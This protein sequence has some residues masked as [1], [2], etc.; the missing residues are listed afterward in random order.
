MGEQ[1]KSM[2]S[3]QYV[4]SFAALALLFISLSG[5]ASFLVNGQKRWEII[6]PAS[7]RKADYV[8]L[9][10]AGRSLMAGHSIY[11]NNRGCGEEFNDP[12]A[13]EN[14]VRYV[15]PPLAAYIFAPLAFFSEKTSYLIWSA[16][17]IAII[18]GI[19]ALT[20][21]KLGFTHLET[22][23]LGT[24][25]FLSY[26][27]WFSLERGNFDALVMLFYLSAFFLWLDKRSEY[28]VAFLLAV[29]IL[30]KLF[31]LALLLFFLLKKEWNIIAY[32]IIAAILLSLL[33]GLRFIPEYGAVF[34]KLLVGLSK[35]LFV[36]NHSTICFILRT[37][38]I[39]GLFSDAAVRISIYLSHLINLSLF[40]FIAYHSWRWG[41]RSKLNLMIE[42]CAYLL[43]MSV[44]SAVSYDYK[45]VFMCFMVPVLIKGIVMMNKIKRR[46]FLTLVIYVCM[47]Y[48]L[49]ATWCLIGNHSGL[50]AAILASKFP[51][52]VVLIVS[53]VRMDSILLYD[54]A[55]SP[56]ENNEE[57]RS[58][59]QC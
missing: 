25:V 59:V 39:C 21:K 9:L 20:S 36:A 2:T 43:F 13:G 37:Q 46:S 14:E 23:I 55:E 57:K 8:P 16:A 15:Y 12:L 40:G 24:V 54:R 7:I 18:L 33:V 42:I 1:Q 10:I 27:I 51:F 22:S 45:L 19:L 11:E 58:N 49:T 48:C 52:M 53:I 44:A 47:A 56:L 31:P 6:P 32:T 4:F 28:L 34:A 5:L 17:Q 50:P 26:P 3:A 41:K 38:A 30:L 35:H 29:A